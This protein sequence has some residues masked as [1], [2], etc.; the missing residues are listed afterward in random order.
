VVLPADIQLIGK[1]LAI[2]WKDGAETYL[3]VPDLRKASPSA[4]VSGEPD[5]F[6][7]KHGGEA[8]VQHQDVKLVGWQKV[9]NYA[10]RFQFSD[11]HQTGIYS[12]DYLRALG[13]VGG[14]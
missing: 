12:Y 10:I 14:L 4:V 6:G 1:E 2:R 9:G 13:E 3:L 11:G 7:R 8:G 5:I